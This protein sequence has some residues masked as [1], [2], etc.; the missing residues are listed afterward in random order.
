MSGMSLVHHKCNKKK[1]IYDKCVSRWY[2]KEF[3]TG[4]SLNQEEICGDKFDAYRTCI[5]K[6]IK[7]EIWDKQNLPPPKAG[8]ALDE[9][10]E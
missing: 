2:T 10:D 5:L 7:R 3:M 1:R 8:S 9:L 4:K 6:G